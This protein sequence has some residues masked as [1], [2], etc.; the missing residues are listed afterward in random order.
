MRLSIANKLSIGAA[1]LVIVSVGLASWIFY[2]KTTELLV[3]ESIENIAK[4]MRVTGQSLKTRINNQ[5]AD[6]LFLAGAPPIQGILNSDNNTELKRRLQDIFLT[7]LGTKPSYLKIRLID[8][9]GQE[10]VVVRRDNDELHV[11][12]ENDLQNK[13]EREYV[14]ETRKLSLGSVYLSEINLNREHGKVSLPHQEVLRSATPI[15]DKKTSKVIGM[16]VVTVEIGKVLHGIQRVIRDAGK[17]IFI[18][19]DRGGYLLHSDINKEYGFDLG[20]RFRVQE[21][22]PA[23]S[24]KYLPDNEEIQLVILLDNEHDQTVVNFT[25]LYIDPAKPE[26][27]I[28][29]GITELYSQILSEQRKLL[30]DIV[31]V[32][33]AFA[34]VAVLLAIFFAYKLS[35]PIKQITKV[36]DDYINERDLSAVM[37]IESDDEIG[38]LARSY[39]TL[40]EQVEEAQQDLTNMNK[41]L[42]SR[43]VERTMKLKQSER[44]QR[45]IVDNMVDGLITIDEKGCVISFNRA[46]SKI[47]GYQPNDIIGNNIKML[48]SEPHHTMH[49]GYLE[50]YSKSG[51]KNIIGVSSEVEG[52]RKDGS[53][54]PLELAVS[55]MIL[56]SKKIYTGV[57]RDITERKQVEKLKNNFVSTVSHELRTPL[58]SIRG[59]L[60][61]IT[62]GAL[63]EVSSKINEMLLMAGNNAERL[64]LL[65][66][67]ILDMQ[68]IEIGE[69]SFFFDEIELST[70]I[71]E[72][73]N[74]SERLS[75]EYGVKFLFGHKLK[76]VYVYADKA[77]LIQVIVNLLSNAVKFS[78]K[79]STVNI[80]LY[81]KNQSL[82]ISVADSGPGIPEGFQPM[83]FDKFTQ[84]DSS[85]TRVNGG[86]GLGLTISRA[87]IERHNGSLTYITSE[88]TGT[89]FTVEL[90]E[91]ASQ[92]NPKAADFNG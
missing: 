43:V 69:I 55:E 21:D 57:L 59:S 49:D 81:R 77:R 5:A 11:V 10:V 86:A 75:K 91:I 68:K 22:I 80:S 88:E 48:M 90:T 73:I 13:S 33:V 65:I 63:G 61:L 17:E 19:N 1:M 20:K 34:V 84:Y 35:R 42:E 8:A 66:N 15:Y 9:L 26:R 36:M 53:V 45:S 32:I 28:A 76:D 78:P 3:D 4:Q 54:F 58:T 60:G 27:F 44:R 25:K 70:L 14:S 7:M 30:D 56:D 89:V 38:I 85:A 87:I 37:P 6:V 82:F 64:L 2:E 79:G 39:L 51:V 83:L 47:F 72:S 31:Y 50:R 18:T 92:G 46:A 74:V 29:V 40:M 71:E 52:L 24:E 12:K 23:I 62:G 41:S 67:D 16:I